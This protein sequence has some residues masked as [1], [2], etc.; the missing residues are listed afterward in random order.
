M[1]LQLLGRLVSGYGFSNRAETPDQRRAVALR[2][3]FFI[4]G[5]GIGMLGISEVNLTINVKCNV[6]GYY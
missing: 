5:M 3:S 2:V 4:S 1:I 6:K